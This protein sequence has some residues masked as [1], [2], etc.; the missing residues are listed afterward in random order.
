LRQNR[1]LHDI[2]DPAFVGFSGGG[3][4]PLTWTLVAL[5][6]IIAVGNAAVVKKNVQNVQVKVSIGLIRTFYFSIKTRTILQ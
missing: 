3:K 2:N 4:N 6:I 5:A 1:P